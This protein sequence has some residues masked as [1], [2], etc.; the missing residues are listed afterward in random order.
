MQLH[1]I[2]D[3]HLVSVQDYTNKGVHGVQSIGVYN[4]MMVVHV[5]KGYR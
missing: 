5:Y 2:G 4:E 1:M 3:Y